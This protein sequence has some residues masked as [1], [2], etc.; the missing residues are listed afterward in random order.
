MM[1]IVSIYGKG[2]KYARNGLKNDEDLI[3]TALDQDDNAEK[4]VF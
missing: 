2:I 3:L 1:K 4:Y